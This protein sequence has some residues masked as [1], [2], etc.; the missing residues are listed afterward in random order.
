[1]LIIGG[2][3]HSGDLEA[4]RAV[5]RAIRVTRPVDALLCTGPFGAV[6]PT[7]DAKWS[8]E[9]ANSDKAWHVRLARLAREEKAAFLDAQLLWGNYV[10]ASGKPLDWFK[11]D[12]VHANARGEAVLGRFMTEYL[13]P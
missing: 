5:L 7:D 2:I 9:R 11:R 6:D 12:P 13:A 10:R 3:S 4:V 1:L 8:A